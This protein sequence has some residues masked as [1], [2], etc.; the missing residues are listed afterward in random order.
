MVVP[1]PSTTDPSM[2]D[3]GR[4]YRSTRRPTNGE[5]PY[6]PTMWSAITYALRSL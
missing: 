5:N 1:A 4:P 6:I 3:I 2:I